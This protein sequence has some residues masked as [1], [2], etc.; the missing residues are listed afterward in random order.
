MKSKEEI[1]KFGYERC[2]FD[3][4]C[5]LCK[6]PEGGSYAKM[7]KHAESNEECDY[8]ICGKCASK[9]IENGKFEAAYDVRIYP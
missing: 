3:D 4:E 6:N 8:Y 5:D 7:I 9:V 1:E 2:D